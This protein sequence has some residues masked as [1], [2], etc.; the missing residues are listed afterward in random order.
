MPLLIWFTMG[1]MERLDKA[2]SCTLGSL[3][4]EA[5]FSPEWCIWN[6]LTRNRTLI[7]VFYFHSIF[8]MLYCMLNRLYVWIISYLHHLLFISL[9]LKSCNY[10]SGAYVSYHVYLL[11]F[12]GLWISVP[13]VISSYNIFNFLHLILY[14]YCIIYFAL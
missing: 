1:K 9:K 14:L 6:W 2:K 7:C 11:M 13:C 4:L 3:S 10:T 12:V 5:N 8:I